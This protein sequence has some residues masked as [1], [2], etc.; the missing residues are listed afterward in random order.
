[1][2]NIYKLF[3]SIFVL[4]LFVGCEDDFSDTTGKGYYAQVGYM[5]PKFRDNPEQYTDEFLKEEGYWDDYED[6]LN[7]G[8]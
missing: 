4:L 7:D 8:S 3:C 5:N 1:M 2:K 6:N